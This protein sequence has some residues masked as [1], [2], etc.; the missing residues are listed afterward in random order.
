MID[1]K[2]K[3]FTLAV[4]ALLSSTVHAALFDTPARNLQADVQ[5]ARQEKKIVAVLATL[6]DCPSCA[7]MERTVFNRKD[8]ENL[9]NKDLISR[10]IDITSDSNIISANG[11]EVPIKQFA[12]QFHVFATPSFLFFDTQGN[13]LYRYSGE[14]KSPQFKK[15]INYVTHGEYEQR[16]FAVNTHEHS[17]HH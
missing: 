1:M 16:P 12:G 13:F 11:K 3:H 2:I 7:K 8:I 9:F 10:R 6:P 4:I 17:H 15:L 14:L 5:Q